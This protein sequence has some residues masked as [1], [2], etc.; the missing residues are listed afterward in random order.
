VLEV[1][2]PDATEKKRSMPAFHLNISSPN[3]EPV[4]VDRLELKVDSVATAKSMSA[5]GPEFARE[6]GL[7]E[8]P[9]P[10]NYMQWFI[11]APIDGKFGFLDEGM[12]KEEA[13]SYHMLP[14]SRGTKAGGS[15]PKKPAA[16]RQ[17]Y[18]TINVLFQPAFP[19][20]Q[21]P[22][23][24][25]GQSAENL[26]VTVRARF[27]LTGS[28]GATAPQSRDVTVTSK[29]I[30]FNLVFPG[31]RFTPLQLNIRKDALRI[32]NIRHGKRYE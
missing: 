25:D 31:T 24:A 18:R 15:D 26:V 22:N 23:F 7:G 19:H 12:F 1:S 5:K 21:H 30:S 28:I 8:V 20:G 32:Y 11:T 4:F 6:P 2:G 14:F 9:Q 17:S 27:V 10:Q 29:E 3:D 13:P 16:K